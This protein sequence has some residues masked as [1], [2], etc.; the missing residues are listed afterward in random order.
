MRRRDLLQFL[1]LIK[2]ENAKC[3][4]IKKNARQHMMLFY[5]G[6]DEHTYVIQMYHTMS[7]SKQISFKCTC[8][9]NMEKNLQFIY[10]FLKQI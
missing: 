6:N 7:G 1:L 10:R 4:S 5:I 3:I 8:P 9:R 2:N